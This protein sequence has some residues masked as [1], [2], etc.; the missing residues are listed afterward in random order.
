M[1]NFKVS[2]KITDLA[3]GIMYDYNEAGRKIVV[4][5]NFETI[6]NKLEEVKKAGIEA[7]LLS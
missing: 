2:Y 5:I 7:M 1:R 4:L 6:D 3:T